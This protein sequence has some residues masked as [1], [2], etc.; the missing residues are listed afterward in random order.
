L[1]EE[2]YLNVKEIL[3][4]VANYSPN[5]FHE[6]KINDRS[7]SC[8]SSEDLESF[9]ISWKNRAS[10][11]L[12]TLLVTKNKYLPSED[13]KIIKKY[14]DLGIIKFEFKKYSRFFAED[15]QYFNLFL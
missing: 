10:K 7:H 12:L 8:I 15:L 5:K 2:K 11:K 3:E 6:L 1:C 4:T 14:V 9:F 13:M